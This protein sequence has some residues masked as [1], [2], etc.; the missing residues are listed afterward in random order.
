LDKTASSGENRLFLEYNNHRFEYKA[1]GYVNVTEMGKIFGKNPKDFFAYQMAK[2]YISA[3][4]RKTGLPEAELKYVVKGNYS[5][6]PNGVIG[7]FSHHSEQGTFCHPKLAIRFAQWLNA[8]FA[9][10]VDEQIL[11]IINPTSNNI[12]LEELSLRAI[13]GLQKRIEELKSKASE[14]DRFLNAEGL[15]SF[16]SASAV[17]CI[18]NMGQNN[19]FKFARDIG[20]LDSNNMPYRQHIEF[21]RVVT[22]SFVYKDDHGNDRDGQKVYLTAKGLSYLAK[23][24]EEHGHVI[25]ATW[26]NK[27]THNI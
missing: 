11:G 6:T 24:L 3:L 21:G 18:P 25:N 9:V 4:S 20:F 10:W 8:D 27:L 23:I 17:F 2:D 16:R 1:N 15:L 12:P 7:E 26:N 22:K 14:W 13:A 19:L 5:P